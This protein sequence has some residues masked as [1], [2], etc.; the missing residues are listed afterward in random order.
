MECNTFVHKA[1]QGS[2]YVSASHPGPFYSLSK[3]CTIAI[4]TYQFYRITL[5]LSWTTIE[6]ITTQYQWNT[7]VCQQYHD[8]VTTDLHFDNVFTLYDFICCKQLRVCTTQ[9]AP[10]RAQFCHV[11]WFP[12]CTAKYREKQQKQPELLI[13]FGLGLHWVCVLIFLS[14]SCYLVWWY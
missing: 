6:L 10:I 9:Y 14:L 3:C 8:P 4:T 1:A 7:H 2:R 5:F 11:S 13:Y 12:F